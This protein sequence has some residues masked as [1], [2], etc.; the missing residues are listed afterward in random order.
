MTSP[1]SRL[2]S[3]PLESG[4]AAAQSLISGAQQTL[5]SLAGIDRSG[6]TGAP[7]QGPHESDGALSD[8]VNRAVRIVRYTPDDA[9]ELPGAAMRLAAA[10]R[11][12]FGY[13]DLMDPRNLVFP[14]QLALSVSRLATQ[15]ALRGL[16]IYEVLGPERVVPLF[17]DFFEMFTEFQVFVGLEYQSVIRRCRERIA[18]APHDYTTRLELGKTLIKCGLYDQAEQ[19]LI[20]IPATSPLFAEA[21][22]ET[23]VAL[24]RAGR[25]ERAARAAVTAWEANPGNPRTKSWLWMTA[26]KLGAYP[27]FV[28]PQARMEVVAGYAKPTLFFTDIA[29]TI[30]LD[31]TSAGRGIAVFDYDNDGYLDILIAAAHGGCNLYHNNGDGT[32]TD[33]SIPSGLDAC[34]NGFAVTVGDYN[35]DGFTDVFVT[36]LGFYGGE[37]QLFRNNGDGTFTDVTKAAGLNVWGP[38]FTACWVDYNR[39]GLLD[40]FIAN[41]L[42]GLFEQKTPNRLFRNNGDGTFTDVAAEAGL[43]TPWPTIGAAWGDYDDDGFPDL[44]VSNSMGRSQ[45]FHNNRNGTFTDVSAAAGVD[46]PCFGSPAFWWDFDNDGWLDIAQFSWSDHEDAIHT[47]EH[48]E[49]PAD[50][51]PMRVYR[52]NR[53]GTFQL[54]SQEIGLNGCWGTMSGNA[55]D[56]NND[57]RLDLVL[58]NGSPK[59]DRL[60]PLVVM[61][62][63]GGTFRNVTFAA[64]FPFLGKSHGVNMAD[65]FG[66]GRLSILVGAGGAYPGDLLTMNVYC[67]TEVPGS[68]LNIR[69][70]GVK[71]NR[72]AIGARLT[73]HAAGL[74]PQMREVSGGSNF[75]CLPF[76][77]HFGLG[78]AATADSLDIR[79]PSGLKQTMTDLPINRTIEIIEGLPGWTDVYVK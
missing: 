44:F 1:F 56:F 16:A 25:L 30:G 77:Q 10:A 53:D 67:P 21:A 38:A 79:W 59:M 61:E 33:V 72:S 8:F 75:G 51:N 12:S 3:R 20:P 50:G 68:Y 70:K 37:G 74:A 9:A 76:E 66:D 62:N 63:Q 65:L 41:N 39:D 27:D 71:S 48:G 13:L 45:L 26:K 47:M 54:V 11:Q 29:A 52:N 4:L 32:F 43:E 40:L 49:G 69:L 64:G 36:R 73:L 57:G 24:F 18:K 22:H 34:V 17:R 60:E 78:A 28:P 19:E 58:G 5:D 7:V 6:S 31:K 35:N 55:G 46:E 23:A 2:L 42:G 14:A 15:S